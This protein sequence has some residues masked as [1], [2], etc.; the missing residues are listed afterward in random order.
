MKLPIKTIFIVLISS[1]SLFAQTQP[2]EVDFQ[3]GGITS[4]GTY[5]AVVKRFGR[6]LQRRTEKY[7]AAMACSGSPETHITL[8]YPGLKV[9]LLGEGR[10][11]DMHVYAV[12]VSS[13]RWLA[14]GVRIGADIKDVQ[15]RF[16]KAHSREDEDI[17]TIL[18][19]VT[20]GNLGGVNF[21]FR[22]GKL[23]RVGMTETLC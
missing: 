14:S 19:Y 9:T 23:V 6:P 18:Y 15:A 10:G 17:K 1:I 5:A 22:A 12:E 7:T 16:G 2:T 21:Y 20:K 13:S 4:G 8:L 3:V 11:R